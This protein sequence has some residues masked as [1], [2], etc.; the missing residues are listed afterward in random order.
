MGSAVRTGG[1]RTSGTRTRGL[2]SRASA[3]VTDFAEGIRRASAIG[4]I[5]YAGFAAV[6]ILLYLVA[7]KQANIDRIV[8]Y[9]IAG[10]G[11]LFGWYFYAR[12]AHASLR[13]MVVTTSL[14]LS[15]TVLLLGLI[16]NELGGLGSAYIPATA[17]YFVAIASLVPSPWRRILALLSPLYVV[18]FVTLSLAACGLADHPV[19][20]NG[21]REPNAS[22]NTASVSGGA[23]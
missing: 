2:R 11:I 15:G 1:D 13:S 9:R 7:Y 6:D 3:E 18:F 22:L 17:F 14:V 5:A 10:V 16:A 8:A 12:S 21:V 23:V 4:S 20:Q 19:A